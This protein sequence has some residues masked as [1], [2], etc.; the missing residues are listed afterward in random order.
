MEKIYDILAE[1]RP[2]N[3]FKSSDDFIEDGLLDSFDIITLIDIIEEK[4]GAKIDGLD[5]VPEN[6]CN[7]EAIA[8]LV[9]KSGGN[10]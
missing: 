5:I 1:I 3:D 4:T 2:E 7:A 9:S 10:I 8:E 6:F